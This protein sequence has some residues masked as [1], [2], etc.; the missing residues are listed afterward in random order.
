MS[1]PRAPPRP[2]MRWARLGRRLRRDDA[3]ARDLLLRGPDR[4]RP[5][6]ARHRAPT[7]VLITPGDPE[8]DAVTT[9]GGT[10]CATPHVGGA[11]A[12]LW[13]QVAADGGAGSV[14]QR[15]RDRLVA[16]ALD[17]G[18][19]GP[20]TVFGAGRLRL[21]LD[22]PVLGAP[23]PAARV[24][25]ARHRRALAPDRRRG[26]ARAPAAVRR[27]PAA[28]RDARARRDPPGRLADPGPPARAARPRSH[29][30]GRERQRRHL[31][32][33]VR[34]RQRRPAGA[35]ASAAAGGGRRQGAHLGVGARHGHGLAGRPRMV[36]GDGAH[37]SGFH[38]AH[39]TGGPGATP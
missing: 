2:A 8:D 23:T 13:N 28:R 14:A 26:H 35:P 39:P 12:L 20:D 10:S 22:P 18:A 32:R 31:P 4:R 36:F 30:G 21:D 19:P 25:R 34:R 15:V 9:C 24:D 11:A 17:M 27:G 1:L 3:A 6:Q 16:Q 33:R 38:L 37:A 29:H 7:N 5:P